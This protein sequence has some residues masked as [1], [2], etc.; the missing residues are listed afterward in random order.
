MVTYGF[1]LLTKAKVVNLLRIKLKYM[2]KLV[3]KSVIVTFQ[4][5]Q[6]L[7]GALKTIANKVGLRSF[8]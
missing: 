3:R 6:V 1:L 2:Y 8:I 4:L 7:Y 5:Q